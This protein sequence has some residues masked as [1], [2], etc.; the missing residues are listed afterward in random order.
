MES[1]REIRARR[2]RKSRKD[3]R[4]NFII[5]LCRRTMAMTIIGMLMK[6]SRTT[7]KAIE[8]EPTD[9]IL[10]AITNTKMTTI[11]MTIGGYNLAIIIRRKVITIKNTKE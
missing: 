5:G 2:I 6:K 3:S 7:A 9:Q 11:S 4:C 8:A 10:R 1:N